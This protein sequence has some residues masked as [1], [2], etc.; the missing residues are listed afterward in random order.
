MSKL[1]TLKH[2][3]E[4][5]LMSVEGGIEN[6]IE[7]L[8]EQEKGSEDRLSK[9]ETNVL[10][11]V[12]SSVEERL[13]KLEGVIDRSIIHKLSLLEKQI[14]SKMTEHINQTVQSSS[15]WQLPFIF[16]ILIIGISGISLNRW[17]RKLKKTHLL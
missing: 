11:Q 7:K 5:E 8:Q 16:L 6:A 4:H 14:D 1:E 3:F 13:E 9:L 10:G 15:G 12:G 2:H 17:Y